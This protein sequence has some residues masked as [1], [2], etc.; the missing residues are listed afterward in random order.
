MKQSVH[1][2]RERHIN[3]GEMAAAQVDAEPEKRGMERDK[4]VSLDRQMM[5]GG[6]GSRQTDGGIASVEAEAPEKLAKMKS[7][8]PGEQME[9]DSGSETTTKGR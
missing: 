9:R 5:V 8:P 1:D 2:Q 6:E 4:H 3:P 7:L